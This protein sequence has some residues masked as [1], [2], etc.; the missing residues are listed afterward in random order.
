MANTNLPLSVYATN[1]I[2]ATTTTGQVALGTA[3][4]GGT[5]QIMNTGAVAIFVQVG[6]DNTVVA[7][8][9]FPSSNMPV[10][11]NSTIAYSVRPD[12]TNVAVICA[13]GTATVYLSRGDGF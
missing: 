12:F 8:N 7:V 11:P 13:S 2:A 3:G 6:V 1:T 9:T 10:A 5:L 4:N